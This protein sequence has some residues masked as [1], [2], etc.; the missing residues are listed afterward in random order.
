[1]HSGADKSS[2]TS[3]SGAT[4]DKSEVSE[5]CTSEGNIPDVPQ[6]KST[7]PSQQERKATR[8]AKEAPSPVLD[9]KPPKAQ[10]KSSNQTVIVNMVE[11]PSGTDLLSTQTQAALL[12]VGQRPGESGEICV[13]VHVPGR[14]SS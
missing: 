7:V 4:K 3:S 6:P 2:R 5:T 13:S 8:H 10:K 12:Q 11:K 9:T 1:M 14:L